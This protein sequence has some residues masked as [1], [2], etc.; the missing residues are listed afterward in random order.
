MCLNCHHHTCFRYKLY[1][2]SKLRKMTLVLNTKTN[3]KT[4]PETEKAYFTK[5][6]FSIFEGYSNWNGQTN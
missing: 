6:P 5:F 1:A 2:M 3:T 4:Y